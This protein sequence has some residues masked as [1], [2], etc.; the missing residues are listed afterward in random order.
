MN[1]EGL[2]NLTLADLE[3]VYECNELSYRDA[4][5][6]MREFRDKHGLNDNQALGAFGIARCI[7]DE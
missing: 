4:L 1:I 7:F 6:V 5:P 3:K 2:E